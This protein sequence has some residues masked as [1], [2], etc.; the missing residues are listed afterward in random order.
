[1]IQND[2][3]AVDT[4]TNIGF[5]NIGIALGTF[6]GSQYDATTK[7]YTMPNS[8]RLGWFANIDA[9]IYPLSFSNGVQFLL[10]FNSG[11]RC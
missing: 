3:L 2:C 7:A 11:S 1:M 6:D 10:R 8:C 9:S 4:W 5:H